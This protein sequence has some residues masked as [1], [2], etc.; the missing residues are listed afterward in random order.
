MLA[1][2]AAIF[3]LI[4]MFPQWILSG[5]KIYLRPGERDLCFPSTPWPGSPLRY[6]PVNGISASLQ[7]AKTLV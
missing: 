6:D 5:R 4:Q 1:E 3:K 7:L 2:I